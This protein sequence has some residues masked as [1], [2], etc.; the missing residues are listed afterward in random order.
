MASAE[1]Y[2]NAQDYHADGDK[3]Q[4]TQSDPDDYW[5]Q[6]Y[7]FKEL[8][9]QDKLKKLTE[10]FLG[11]EDAVTEQEKFLVNDLLKTPPP[12]T[13]IDGTIKLSPYQQ[14]NSSMSPPLDLSISTASSTWY[15][16]N[17]EALADNDS[18]DEEAD[19]HRFDDLDGISSS[20]DELMSTVFSTPPPNKRQ[21]L[22][23]VNHAFGL[24]SPI[25][26]S[27]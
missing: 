23:R 12:G 15:P 2:T 27:D 9:Q 8:L 5:P 25:L 19:P 20:D 3:L 13:T 18:S 16:S 26:V 21:R 6:F 7:Y 17:S 4:Q 22:A 10:K 11:I 14:C 24:N 1:E